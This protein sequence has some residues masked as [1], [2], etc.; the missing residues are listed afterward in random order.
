[1]SK[2]N[3]YASQSE[4]THRSRVPRGVQP[5][6]Y[7]LQGLS[8]RTRLATMTAITV[9]ISIAVITG[10]AY[11]TVSRGLEQELDKNLHTQAQ[12]VI[13][14]GYT[15]PAE[16]EGQGDTYQPEF[17]ENNSDVGVLVVPEDNT[18]TRTPVRKF[19]SVLS[20]EALGV[21]EGEEIYSYSTDGH[22]RYFAVR[23][24]DGKVLVVRQDITFTKQTLDALSLVLLLVAVT[25]FLGAIVTGIAVASSALQP[26]ARL[27]RATDRVTKTG[28]LR[29]IP[30]YNRDELGALT[31]SFN[32]MME[33]LQDA[34]T[35]QKN[36]VADASHELKTPLTSLRTN[37][38]LLM[39]ASKSNSPA[40]SQ[41]DRDDIERDVIAQIEE[42]STLIGD[43]VDLAREDEPAKEL[44]TVEVSQIIMEGIDRVQRR[45]PDVEFDTELIPWELRGDQFGLSRALL[46]VLDN[47]AK[48]SPDG[49]TVRIRMTDLGE[50][51]RYVDGQPAVLISV[52][53]SGP[54]IAAEDRPNIFDRFYRSISSR[55]MP[56]S[57]LGLA[58]VKQVI[59]RHGG[60]VF[61]EESDDGGTLMNVVLPGEAVSSLRG[62]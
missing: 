20:P 41:Q 19:D 42:M 61:A 30:V 38:E 22:Y 47:A 55:S 8:L 53:D 7:L 28:Q 46:N 10:V 1:M 21:I 34:Q 29:Q 31:E 15:F 56:G 9:M 24:A 58:I 33:A 25:G 60:V 49:A 14:S 40:M 23:A 44:T 3:F 36:L 4:S 45:R 32:D 52:A 50:H 35:K 17:R 54:G 37:V 51:S 39:L 43:L 59:D 16:Q 62:D 11:T 48:W 6:L 2:R 57:G 13:D 26:I 12:S 5:L 18:G 27:R